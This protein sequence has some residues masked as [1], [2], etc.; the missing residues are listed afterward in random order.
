[1]QMKREKR[2]N[3]FYSEEF[4]LHVVQELKQ[5]NLSARAISRKYDIRGKC[6]LAK[7]LRIYGP[8]IIVI[9]KEK[10]RLLDNKSDYQ[11]LEQENEKLKQTLNNMSV[12]NIAQAVYIQ[13]L[14]KE[15]GEAQKK[16]L[17]FNL[18]KELQTMFGKVG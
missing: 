18:S 7:W 13:E 2:Q 9:P 1:M 16:K 4:K 5:G 8:E 11:A 14:S 6:T 12:Q 15:V 3:T 10:L 17:R